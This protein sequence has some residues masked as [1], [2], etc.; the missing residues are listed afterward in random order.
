LGLDLYHFRVNNEKRGEPCGIDASVEGSAGMLRKF[1]GYSVIIHNEQTDW[2]A[3]FA[4]HGLQFEHFEGAGVAQTLDQSATQMVGYYAFRR[5]KNG[6]SD[7]PALIIFNNLGRDDDLML[8]MVRSRQPD[9]EATVLRGPLEVHRVAQTAVFA[10]KLGINANQLVG[11]STTSS[12]PTN[13]LQISSVYA[14]SM[15]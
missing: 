12:S 2:D 11:P 7:L 13:T 3:T 5:R 9:V 6:P 14:E 4:A 10:S 15:N 8:T 1:G